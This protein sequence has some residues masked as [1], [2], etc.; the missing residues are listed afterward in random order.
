MNS[1]YP[2]GQREFLRTFANPRLQ[3]DR[4]YYTALRDFTAE[5]EEAMVMEAMRLSLL[6]A[7]AEEGQAEESQ[8]QDRSEDSNA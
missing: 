5:L 1:G 3:I 4:D 7:P 6:D 2:G 8:A